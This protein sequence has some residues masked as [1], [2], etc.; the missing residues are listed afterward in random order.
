MKGISAIRE[1]S[2]Q[3]TKIP[4]ETNTSARYMRYAGNKSPRISCIYTDYNLT[5][6]DTPRH[7]SRPERATP[8]SPGQATTESDT[9][10]KTPYHHLRPERAKAL[11]IIFIV[12]F[13]AYHRKSFALSGRQANAD[14]LY[15]GCRLTLF[16][17]PWARRFWPFRP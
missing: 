10:G 14:T 7:H 16:A 4:C 12:Q 2:V 5:T 17:L 8:P 13:S 6:N 11:Y 1:I 9:L 3:K 15:P